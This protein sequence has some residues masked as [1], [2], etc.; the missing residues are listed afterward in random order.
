[1]NNKAKFPFKYQENKKDKFFMKELFCRRTLYVESM[2]GKIFD[3]L[4]LFLFK[5]YT[6]NTNKKYVLSGLVNVSYLS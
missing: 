6:Q 5:L 1:M 3:I 2:C 4:S